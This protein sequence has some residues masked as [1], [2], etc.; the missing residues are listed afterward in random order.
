VVA[1]S[2][3]KMERQGQRRIVRLRRLLIGL[4]I[5][6]GRLPHTHGIADRHGCCVACHGVRSYAVPVALVGE[7]SIPVV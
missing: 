3:R 2:R 5:D 1:E 6:E 7:C 4:R